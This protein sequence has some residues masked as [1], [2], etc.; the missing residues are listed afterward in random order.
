LILNQPDGHYASFFTFGPRERI[1]DYFTKLKTTYE[2]IA[3]LLS[4]K[5]L[6]IQLVSFA[7]PGRDVRRYLSTMQAAGFEE[8][9]RTEL[10]LGAGYRVRRVVPNRKWY[11]RYQD[12]PPTT[13][14]VLLVHRL[15]RTKQRRV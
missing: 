14:E 10:G 9:N 5:A 12:A 15:V 1:D 7:N 13:K 4:Q 8:C 3:A 6:V 2:G 11:M